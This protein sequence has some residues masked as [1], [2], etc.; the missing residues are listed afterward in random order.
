MTVTQ[1]TARTAA[2]PIATYTA[3]SDSLHYHPDTQTSKFVAAGKPESRL[4]H[5][6][7]VFFP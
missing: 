7:A 2:T 4:Q 5:K 6:G 1:P 3:L